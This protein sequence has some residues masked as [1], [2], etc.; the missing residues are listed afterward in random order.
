MTR[1]AE[2]TTDAQAFAE[3]G[4]V[5]LTGMFAAQRR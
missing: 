5:H 4:Y 3:H 1:T 2:W